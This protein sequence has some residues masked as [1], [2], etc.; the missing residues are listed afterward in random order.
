M[1]AMEPSSLGFCR[2][3]VNDNRDNRARL[4]HAATDLFAR[5]GFH[6]TGMSDL[7]QAT[8]LGRSSLYHYFAS[9]EALLV[10]IVQRCLGQLVVFGERLL[11]EESDPEPRLRRFSR[12]VV[13]GIAERPSEL[14]VC[15]H[16]RHVFTG[17]HRHRVAG[18][19][20][21]YERIWARIL[22]AGHAD[23]VFRNADG[24]TVTAVMGMHHQAWSGAGRPGDP[25]RLA[26]GFCDLLLAGLREPPVRPL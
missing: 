21:E 3:A 17:D 20:Q 7:E 9:K 16:E 8:G 10:A 5:Q 15:V 23:G 2:G 13:G 14:R 24:V 4:L 1:M 18:F 12:A 26:D 22:A 6:A 25:D 19:Y 11:E